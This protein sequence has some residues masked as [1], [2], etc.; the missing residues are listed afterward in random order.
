MVNTAVLLPRCS[1][2]T[3]PPDRRGAKVRCGVVAGRTDRHTDTDCAGEHLAVDHHSPLQPH[4]QA[5]GETLDAGDVHRLVGH[6]HEL[7]AAD[8]RDHRRLLR[9]GLQPLGEHLDELVARAVAQVVVDGL[10]P[11]EVEEEHRHRTRLAVGEPVIEMRHQRPTVEQAGQVVML[12]EVLQLLFGGD[13]GLQLREQR[14][15]R[16]QRVLLLRRPFAVAR[17]DEA[18]D[19]GGD[20]A[21]QQGH[22]RHRHRRQAT[23]LLDA[24]LVVVVVRLRPQDQRRLE[25]LRLPEDGVG[26][27]EIDHADRIGVRDVVADGPFGHELGGLDGVVVVPQEAEVDAEVVDEVGEYPGAAVGH[28]GRGGG[29]QLRRRR[30]HD[31]IEAAGHVLTVSR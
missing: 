25:V 9:A 17:L 15:D 19:A 31:L 2:P 10:E 8:P 1:S 16:L 14:C 26:L 30:G 13:A 4:L 20:V 12:G 18:E 11:V 24:A 22:A 6:H 3:G 7:V 28:V 29:H 21:G 5:A 23:A 27:G